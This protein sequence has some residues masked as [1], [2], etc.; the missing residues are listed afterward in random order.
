MYSGDA[1]NLSSAG[2]VA[3]NVHYPT[4]SIASPLSPSSAPFNTSV[5][6]LTITGTGF[7]SGVTSVEFGS[8]VFGP[9]SIT[10]LSATTLTVNLPS[11]DLNSAGNINV[12]V[13]VQQPDLT[14]STSNAATFIVALPS[15]T[16]VSPTTIAVGSA[17]T[18]VAVT[19]S[20]FF[21]TSVALWH[22]VTLSA[23]NSTLQYSSGSAITVTLP[24]SAL[25]SIY[26]GDLTVT[27][28]GG[29]TSSTSKSDI[30]AT[31]P[32]PS[33]T[34][35][36]LSLAGP[37]VILNTSVAGTSGIMP[38][39]TVQYYID[40]KALAQGKIN[41]VGQVPAFTE[42]VIPGTHTFT[43]S[44][45]GD[46]NNAP[47]TT[48]SPIVTVLAASTST[49]VK[50]SISPSTAGGAVTLTATVTGNTPTGSVQF[51]IDGVK[52]GVPIA[53]SSGVAN[54][55]LSSLA[56]GIHTVTASYSGD[57][58]NTVSVGT[59]SQKVYYPVPALASLLPSYVPR[60]VAIS[61]LTINGSGFIPG[62]TSVTIGTNSF[63]A[64]SVIVVATG[65]SLTVVVPAA[66]IATAGIDAVGLKVVQPDGTF[67]ASNSLPLTVAVPAVTSI[68]PATMPVGA[69]ATTLAIHGSGFFSGITAT[70]HGVTFS[71]AGGNLS[72]ISATEI[73]IKVP[74]TA[75]ASAFSGNVVV[76]DPGGSASSSSSANV[77][78][79][80]P[81]PTKVAL[82]VSLSGPVVTTSASVVGTS[83]HVPTGTVIFYLDGKSLI[84]KSLSSAGMIPSF[85]Y[86]AL[87]GVHV[88]TAGYGGDTNNAKGTSAAITDTVLAATT[89]TTVT[90][91]GTPSLIGHAVTFT[92]TIKGS[93]PNGT[94]QFYVDSVATGSPVTL[95]D[96]VAKWTTSTL[97]GGLIQSRRL[98]PAIRTIRQVQV[99]PFR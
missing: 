78:A 31:V 54:Y 22:G 82:S 95:A 64:L 79:A 1:Y 25:S 61:P 30:I 14:I 97:G 74:A 80:V 93:G 3:Q 59:V 67:A 43:A 46:V 6:P 66:D 26:S 68:I 40:G 62:A 7:V 56:V 72:Y 81:A 28:L 49:I 45:V 4:P 75:L 57:A 86:S 65:K 10:V 44:Y 85:S 18:T 88:F 70:W 36:T 9:S 35:L 60:S 50:T 11:A 99:V 38:T 48:T 83:G 55:T 71:A 73:S 42:R 98:I 77:F 12:T 15:V 29:S 47:S 37:I 91:S 13:S 34:T 2:S 19:G 84:A 27:N 96:G 20:G 87:P 69:I 51:A 53:L 21:P 94:V 41:G 58:Y 39:G 90:T 52:S 32:A 89:T 33:T 63:A 24:A 23:A 8:A 92:A 76:T 16:S 17:A 5:T